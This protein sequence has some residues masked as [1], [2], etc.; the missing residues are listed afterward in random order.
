MTPH[1]SAK[2]G[3][4]AKTVLMPGDPLRAKY[5]AEHYFESPELVN[6]VRGV[7]GYTGYYNSVPVT[8]M[9]SGMG[10][11]SISVYARELFSLYDV[12]NII[13]VGSAGA[14]HADMPLGSVVA[15]M[16]ACTDSN[17]TAQ[18]E[19]GAYFAPTADYTLL[20]TAVEYARRSGTDMAVGSLYSSDC[21][22][23]DAK[24]SLRM[25]KLGVL[26]VEMEAAGLYVA[27]AQTGKRALAICSISDNVITGDSMP[28]D[29][30]VVSFNEM[31]VIALETAALM[32][33]RRTKILSFSKKNEKKNE[34]K[35]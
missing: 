32:E 29:E 19:L 10:I 2:P 5:I 16:S 27:A 34:K 12:D 35:D 6:N 14:L 7:Q 28:P 3:D 21:F 4:I 17:I 33:K 30:R 24:R 23:D 31:M 25:A 26:A 20:E 22:Y 13:R 15:G 18:L 9:A 8:V 11:P 1:N